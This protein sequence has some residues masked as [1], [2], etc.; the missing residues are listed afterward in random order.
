MKVL[1]LSDTHGNL[2]KEYLN[3]IKRDNNFDML[4]HCGDCCKDLKY[5]INQ[6]GISKY[7][8]VCGNCDFN[9]SEKDIEKVQICGKS[10]II[11]HGHVF[12]VKRDLDK[13]KYYAENENADI[14]LFGHTHRAYSCYDN[15]I[16][17]FNP[18]STCLPTYGNRSYGIITIDDEGLVIDEI[19]EF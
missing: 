13:L 11:T 19:V 1:V 9:R 4:I 12:D 6:I 3:K 14:V 5:I 8:N 17:Y 15:G 10:I 2:E 7:I 18:G 16:L